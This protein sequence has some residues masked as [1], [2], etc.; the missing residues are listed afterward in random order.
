[1]V[2]FYNPVNQLMLFGYG[3]EFNELKK[4]YE[5]NEEY[6]TCEKIVKGIK[7]LKKFK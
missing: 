1:M 5:K 2:S 4:C 6:E 7:F 3:E